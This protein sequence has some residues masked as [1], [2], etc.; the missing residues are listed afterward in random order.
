VPGE[1]QSGWRERWG[2][3]SGAT[4]GSDVMK[5][6]SKYGKFKRGGILHLS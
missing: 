6:A 1:E 2:C 3:N 5:A 4:E